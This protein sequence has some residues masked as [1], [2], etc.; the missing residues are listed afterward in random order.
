MAEEMRAHVELQTHANLA[1]GM[2]PDEARYAARRQF[3]GVEQIKEEC[4]EQRG[5]VRLENWVRDLRQ[6][7]RS[8]GRSPG[9]SLSVFL[10]LVLCIGPNTA[11]LSALYALVVAPLPFRA[12]GQLVVV[13]NVETK[14]GNIVS[15][16]GLPQ[17]LDFTDQADRFERFALFEAAN[18]TIGE[19]DVPTRA[20]GYRV[21][22]GLFDLLGI[23]PRLGRF[24]SRDEETIGREHVLVL[25]HAFWLK[26]YQGDP[27]V[28]GREVRM[29]G[30]VFT[31]VGVAPPSIES[32]FM[33]VDFFRPFQHGP[34]DLSPERRYASRAI[35][36]GRLKPGVTARDGQ[37][38]LAAIEERF[39]NGQA[40]PGM[41]AELRRGGFRVVVEP[42][43]NTGLLVAVQPL[44]I[45]EG[46][47]LLVLLVGCVN[48]ANL[49][50]AR[51]NAKRPEL[52]IRMALGAG[53]STLFRQMFCE[54]LLLT[55]LAALAGIGVGWATLQLI[56]RSLVVVERL[57]PPIRL[58]GGIVATILL[59][60]AGIAL[61]V[62][63]VPLGLLRRAGF[64][65]GEARTSSA[66]GGMRFLS[67][68]L[69]VGQ[70]ALA[71]VLLVGSGL[72]IR[73]FANVMAVD[74]GFDAAH[75]VQGR[76]ALSHS[77]DD[78][79]TNVAIRLRLTEAMKEIP[80][81]TGVASSSYF[82]VGPASSY[83]SLP[84][85]VRRA[86][87][88]GDEN[89][90]LAYIHPVSAGFFATMGTRFIEGRD[91]TAADDGSGD[92]GLI[93]DRTFAERY[94]PGR[95]ALGEEVAFGAGPF[96]ANYRWPR[97]IGVVNRVNVVG[98]EE[99][100]GLPFI[101]LAMG[102]QASPGFDLLVSSRRPGADIV[103]AMRTKL[104]AVDPTLPLYN[105]GTLRETLDLMLIPRRASMTLLTVFSG[106]ALILAAVGLYGVLAYDVS[107]RTR[108]IGI[109]GAIG[110]S[111]G[112]IVTM[113]L[114][115]GMRKTGL[116]LA[117]GLGGAVYLTQ[118]L[119]K[120]LFD[121]GSTDPLTYLGVVAMLAAV[122]LLASW[123][124]AR[125]AARVDP[126]IALR[127]E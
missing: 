32:L 80:G 34:D 126:V 42:W 57:V 11:V 19:E 119:H 15:N 102:Q 118:F 45:L 104:H 79:K 28:I 47:A 27:G 70:V 56:N 93:V 120:L 65:L 84:F 33:R 20:L 9:F 4:R 35:L 63:S 24:F 109:R 95:S 73:S 31:I 92:S 96:G 99:R 60:G 125:R 2:P 88:A 68:S 17:Y 10:T 23:V 26:Q 115:Q 98:L 16:S 74:P 112:Q 82:G 43:R 101:Y 8:L 90:P 18:T 48:V 7:A 30:E 110:A 121:V 22:A 76:I 75:V 13:K 55:G 54:V 29:G 89:R 58:D 71:L 3:G 77:Y 72:L 127:A 1:A 123:L 36:A 69:V 59:L 105:A 38:Q 111:R 12:P 14:A 46:A 116:G 40:S 51:V 52:A 103:A 108:E 113:I 91:F 85:T 97:I 21:T 67:N 100:D 94:F 107:Q 83:R 61:I 64:R 106:L 44:W 37:T 25:T 6:A 124:P 62:G 41:Q 78:P 87:L 53:W 66:S 5:W 81:V 39:L 117:L 122:A 50:L 49:M 86:P 114:R